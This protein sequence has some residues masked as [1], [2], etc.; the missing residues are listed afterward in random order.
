M[1]LVVENVPLGFMLFIKNIELEANNVDN[2]MFAIAKFGGKKRVF[3]KNTHETRA[4]IRTSNL[5]LNL[6]EYFYLL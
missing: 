3:M 6:T 2:N 5:E 1:E 4:F